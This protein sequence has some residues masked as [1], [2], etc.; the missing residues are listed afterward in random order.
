MHP[1]SQKIASLQRQLLW[2]RRAVAACWVGA[3]AILA[4]LIIGL[5]DYLVRFND[6]GLRIMA[7]AAFLAALTWAV[8]HYWYL[9]QQQRLAPLATARRVQ[10]RFPQLHDSLASAVEF[11]GQSEHDDTAG[12]AQLRRLVVA[13][14]QNNIEAFPLDDVIDRGP[15]RKASFSLAMM[16]AVTVLFVVVD[17]IAVR[18]GL[19][20][21][22]APL[23]STQWPR[24][25]YLEFREVPTQLAAG[26]ALNLE[27]IDKA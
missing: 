21:L 25:H 14:A 27:L 7:T 1:L 26:Q 20:R 16:V 10:A 13:E 2:H 18:T 11:L 15:L 19:T 24:Q 12:S 8:Y 4:A 3:T 17:P 9:P 6:P 22:A 23:G 5:V